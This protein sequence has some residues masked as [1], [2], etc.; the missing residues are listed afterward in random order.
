M[1]LGGVMKDK[2]AI[3]E[4]LLDELV[5]GYQKPED[6]IGE[7][8]LLKQLTKAVFERALHAEFE[9]QLGHAK[10]GSVGNAGGNNRL[11]RPCG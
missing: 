6:L 8:G 9:A 1:I 2:Q 11:R 5:K 10:N 4:A 3:P 7:N